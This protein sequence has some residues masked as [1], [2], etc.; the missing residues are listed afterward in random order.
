M[1]TELARAA[2]DVPDANPLSG[3]PAAIGE[4]Q[5]WFRAACSFCHGLRAE[6]GRGGGPDL[7]GFDKGFRRFVE[8]VKIG[9][10]VPGRALKM[11]AWGGVLSDQQIYQ[12]G[13]YL[14]TLAK[15]GANWR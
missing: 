4:G 7:R 13:A 3:N 10:D 11:P 15:E 9:R 5:S 14:E 8:T 6:G 12:I 2:S 1:G